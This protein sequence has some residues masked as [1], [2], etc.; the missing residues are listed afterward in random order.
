MIGIL[1]DIHVDTSNKNEVV[2]AIDHFI[3]SCKKNK[4]GRV[5]IAGDL[6]LVRKHQTTE[7]LEVLQVVIDMFRA[8]DIHLIMFAGNHDKVDQT[9][10][11]SYISPFAGQDGVTVCNSVQ[12]I[13]EDDLNIIVIPFYTKA[14]YTEE[15]DKAKSLVVTDAINVCL[16]HIDIDVPSPESMKSKDFSDFD[17]TLSGHHHDCRVV[18]EEPYVYYVG[19]L[20]QGGFDEDDNKGGIL[21]G[22]SGEITRIKV[23]FKKYVQITALVGIS[24]LDTVIKSVKAS[25]K[26]SNVFAVRVKVVGEKESYYEHREKIQEIVALGVDVITDLSDD[27]IYTSSDVAMHTSKS[28]KNEFVEFAEEKGKDKLSSIEIYDKYTTNNQP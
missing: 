2:L 8:A 13:R 7:S 23:P 15:L 17:M 18:S 14:K 24:D 11:F 1:A 9:K 25:L 28:L 21:F 12:S 16:T 22:E 27:M 20:V 3:S 4:V 19:S 6:F 5:Y 10:D 26:D